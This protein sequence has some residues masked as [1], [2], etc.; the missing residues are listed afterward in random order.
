MPR[1]EAATVRG[2]KEAA[3][4]VVTRERPTRSNKPC[5]QHSTAP[6]HRN[7]PRDLRRLALAEAMGDRP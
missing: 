3:L 4:G 7:S 6:Q 5:E 2:N 1:R